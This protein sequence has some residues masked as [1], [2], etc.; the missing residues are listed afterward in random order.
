MTIETLED[1]FIMEISDMYSAEKQLTKALPKMAKAATSPELKKGFEKHLAETEDQI[2]KLEQVFELCEIKPKRI[3]C[4][5]MEGLIEE[6]KEAIDEV[7]EGPVRDVAL[8][9]AAQKVEHYEIAGYGCLCAVAK[10]LGYKEAAAIL[11]SILEQERATD[12]KLTALAESS[13]NDDAFDMAQAA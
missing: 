12:E 6:G 9:T 13:V 4:E 8:I 10:K 1:L 11:H 5:A 7:A 2:V 3:K